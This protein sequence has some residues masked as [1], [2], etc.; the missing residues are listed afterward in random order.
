[1]DD[2]G[3]HVVE[4]AGVVRHN[5]TGHIRKAIEVALKPLDVGDVQVIGRLIEQE[6]ISAHEH[7]TGQCKFHFPTTRQGCDGHSSHLLIKADTVEDCD[8]AALVL[9]LKGFI[10]DN[11]VIHTVVHNRRVQVVLDVHC[12]Q[13][14]LWWK[15]LDLAIS[16][17]THECRLAR[18]ISTAQT[19]ST[20]TSHMQ[21]CLVKQDL[22][23]IG[24]RECA[25]AEILA[26]VLLNSAF[27][28]GSTL[29]LCLDTLVQ[30]GLGDGRGISHTLQREIWSDASRP[31][32]QIEVV[33]DNESTAELSNVL[34][35]R[36]IGT[37]GLDGAGQR[38]L[39]GVENHVQVD[40]GNWNSRL[41]DVSLNGLESSKSTCAHLTT[42]G[43]RDFIRSSGK[44]RE[45]L[46]KEG[47]RISGVI[48]K[49]GHVV[50]DHSG[51]TLDGSGA[52]LKTTDKKGHNNR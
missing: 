40:G 22:G 15:A 29:L 9:T 24:Q 43:I 48:D 2:V 47:R 14:L 12:L 11:E 20:A 46:R 36:C 51:L 30:E 16:N 5:H 17:S 6:D 10:I 4:E 38:R 33:G 25:V 42:F 19:I 50:N 34:K 32:S 49:L 44:S 18:S 26:F 52:F 7:S 41:L 39:E 8:N 1:M 28:G 3:T 13:D 27:K 45:Q 31:F 21:H 37:A 35:S 23:T